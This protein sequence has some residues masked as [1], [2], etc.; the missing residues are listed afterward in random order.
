LTSSS[1]EWN[2]TSRGSLEMSPTKH[3]TYL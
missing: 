1:P 2:K 3:K